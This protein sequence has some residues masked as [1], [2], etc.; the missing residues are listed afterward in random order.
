[1]GLCMVARK[2]VGEAGGLATH[3]V[4]L[5]APVLP[6]IRSLVQTHQGSSGAGRILLVLLKAQLLLMG[7]ASASN[8]AHMHCSMNRLNLPEQHAD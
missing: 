8:I 7:M 2:R 6:E 1:M 3:P 5:S 4:M